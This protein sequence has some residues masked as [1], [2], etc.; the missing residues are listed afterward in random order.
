VT[1]LVALLGAVED[2]DP[3]GVLH[4]APPWSGDSDAACVGPDEDAPRGLT[5]LLE[6]DTVRD[7]AEVWSSWRDGRTPTPDDLAAAVIHYAEHDS[8]LP[9]QAGEEKG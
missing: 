3:D 2:L 6:V 1:T 7:V 5:Y 4:A 9:R 8:Y